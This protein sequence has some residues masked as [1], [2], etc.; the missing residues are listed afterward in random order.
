[1]TKQQHP[2]DRRTEYPGLG[3]I[4]LILT[5]RPKQGD[6]DPLDV[7]EIGE[8]VGYVGLK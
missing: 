3:K 7:C 8:A 1:M 5:L 6:N 2:L 4:R